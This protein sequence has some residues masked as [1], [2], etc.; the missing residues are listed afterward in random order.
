MSAETVISSIFV[1]IISG[2]ILESIREHRKEGKQILEQC[3]D[4]IKDFISWV[5]QRLARE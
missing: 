2:L 4:F 1:A 3:Y 5:L